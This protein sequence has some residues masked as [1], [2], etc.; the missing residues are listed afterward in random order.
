MKLCKCCNIEKDILDFSKNKSSKDGLQF[1]CKLCGN[2][3]NKRSRDKKGPEEKSE[4]RKEMYNK[5]KERELRKNKEW[6]EKNSS[7]YKAKS[8]EHYQ[9][10]KKE[11]N[12]KRKIRSQNNCKIR[13]DSS[14]RKSI[15][16]A[17][18]GKK[19][20]QSWKYLAGY[21]VEELTIYLESKFTKN[22]SWENYGK[23]GWEIDHII[24]KMFFIYDSPNNPSFKACWALKNLQ[25]LWATTEIAISYGESN[26]YIGNR[27]KGNRIIITKEIQDLL[28]SVNI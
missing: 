1:F 20:G 15:R 16:L 21:S 28:D 8:K 6:K 26:N 27:E 25:P 13:V 7:R 17:L 24:P 10:N 3:A 4:A 2:A 9:I 19:A 14:M 23:N 5:N 11:I 18:N 22:M 12:L